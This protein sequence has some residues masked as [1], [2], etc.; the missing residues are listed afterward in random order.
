MRSECQSGARG[1]ARLGVSS[2]ESRSRYAGTNAPAIKI[3]PF[4]AAGDRSHAS[5]ARCRPLRTAATPATDRQPWSLRAVLGGQEEDRRIEAVGVAQQLLAWKA[6]IEEALHDEVGGPEQII[7]ERVLLL[8]VTED[9]GVVGVL[10]IG[11]QR[12]PEPLAFR[13]DDLVGESRVR[14]RTLEDNRDALGERPP[15]ACAARRA[16]R[17]VR[18]R[19]DPSALEALAR[20]SSR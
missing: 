11:R 7:R 1:P 9:L 14:V 3:V 16:A 20:R 10:V 6:F 4:E 15:R 5:S 17:R 18:R 12:D 8:F 2:S 13:G 19:L